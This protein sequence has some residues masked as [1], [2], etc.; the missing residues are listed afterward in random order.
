[1]TSHD[2]IDPPGLSERLGIPV[3]TLANWRWRRIG[4]A[5]YTYGRHVRYLIA[6][7]E[8]WEA[9]QRVECGGAA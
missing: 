1:M 8:A 5:Y 7:V 2:Y 3:G 9:T 4:P 6:D